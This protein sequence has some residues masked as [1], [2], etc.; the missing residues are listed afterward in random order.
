[1]RQFDIVELSDRSLALLLQA[2]L[3]DDTLTRVVAPL[4]KATLLKPTVRLHP[5]FR[6]GRHD[7]VVL[8]DQLAAIPRNEIGKS[9]SSMRDREWDIRRALDLLF[10]G[11]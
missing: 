4:V 2:D 1:V 11:V 9:L 7:Y 3:L 5:I 8:M 10:V 6:I